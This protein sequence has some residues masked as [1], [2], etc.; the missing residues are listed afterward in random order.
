M[1]PLTLYIRAIKAIW[2]AATADLR[3]LPPTSEA[4]YKALATI[5]EA[6]GLAAAEAAGEFYTTLRANAG[7]EDDFELVIP[8]IDNL[9]TDELVG[10]ASS[11][12]R[13]TESF[14]ELVA[15]GLQRRIANFARET[16]IET[17]RQDPRALGWMRIGSPE[18]AF[19]AMLISRGAVYSERSATFASHDNCDCQAVPAFD[20]SQVRSVNRQFVASARRRSQATTDADRER[21][22]EWIAENL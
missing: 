22:R 13:T 4:F 16:V 12:A 18:C 19:C 3:K 2:L 17:T 21:A 1:N 9:G 5:V 14:V 10:W 20:R 15:G 6:Y 11:T 7:Y 8:D